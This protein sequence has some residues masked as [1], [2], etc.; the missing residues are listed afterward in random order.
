MT[1][2][3]L[4]DLVVVTV[5]RRTSRFEDGSND[6]EMTRSR[7]TW[8]DPE[9]AELNRIIDEA[10]NVA[11]MTTRLL[12]AWHSGETDA[13]DSMQTLWESFCKIRSASG[14]RLECDQTQTS[15]HEAGTAL[16]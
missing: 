1:S 11:L 5:T 14:L 2:T 3:G 8:S 4:Q 9:E 6:F 13:Q 16:S 10:L 15:G 7:R 12:V